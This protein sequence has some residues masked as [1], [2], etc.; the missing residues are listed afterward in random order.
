MLVFM[1]NFGSMTNFSVRTLIDYDLI[2]YV[3]LC[4]HGLGLSLY[5]G[6]VPDVN[7][8]FVENRFIDRTTRSSHIFHA[9]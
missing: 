1:H 8:S 5:V 2:I 3:L 6:S 7:L 9:L 4:G